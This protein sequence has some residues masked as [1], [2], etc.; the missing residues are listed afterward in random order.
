MLGAAGSSLGLHRIEICRVWGERARTM[1]GQGAV[2]V[3]S[4]GASLEQEG[5]GPAVWG[6]TRLGTE[7]GNGEEDG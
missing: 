5:A 2:G 6:H 1:A 4:Q 3:G 7:G